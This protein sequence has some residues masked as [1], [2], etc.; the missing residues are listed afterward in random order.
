ME[1]EIHIRF[2][3]QDDPLFGGPQELSSAAGEQ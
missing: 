1:Y 2:R 3:E